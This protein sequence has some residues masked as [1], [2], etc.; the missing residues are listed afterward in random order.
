VPRFFVRHP[1]RLHEVL[2]RAARDALTTRVAY[3]GYDE[4]ATGKPPLS[5]PP[6]PWSDV[7]RRLVPGSLWF[8]AVYF[9]SGLVALGASLSR[10]LGEPE[11]GLLTLYGVLVGFSAAVLLVPTLTMAA[12]DSRYS[13]TFASSFDV[14]LLV[15]VMAGLWRAAEV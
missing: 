13:A 4:K 8:I 7:R 11:R 12:F 9:A 10:R 3:S 1:D 5:Q 14:A 6:A 2:A 15:L